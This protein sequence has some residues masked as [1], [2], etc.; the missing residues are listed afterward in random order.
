M[1]MIPAYSQFGVPATAGTHLQGSKGA[2]LLPFSGIPFDD[3]SDALAAREGFCVGNDNT[4]RARKAGGTD[5]CHG[6]GR[7]VVK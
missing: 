1:D 6:H 3:G 4:C 2:K 5:L 7:R